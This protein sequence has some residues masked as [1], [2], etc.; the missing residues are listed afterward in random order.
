M[1]FFELRQLRFQGVG[2]ISCG[3]GEIID[4]VGGTVVEA[5]VEESGM[6]IVIPPNSGMQQNSNNGVL[7]QSTTIKI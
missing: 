2:V 5:I 6:A 7:R 3:R 1:S 4:I